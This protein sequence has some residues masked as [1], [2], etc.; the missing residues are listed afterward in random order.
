MPSFDEIRRIRLKNDYLEMKL[1]DE[2]PLVDVSV[3]GGEEPYADEYLL[4]IN[5]R[6]Y[7]GQNEMMD[8]CQVRI[9]LSEDYPRNAPFAFM[10]GQPK[11]YNPVWFKNGKWCSGDFWNASES[12][13]HFVIRL[14]QSLQFDPAV[15][16][17][18]R[19]ANQE[20]YKWYK[21][22]PRLFPCDVQ[23]LPELKT[24]GIM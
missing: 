19:P 5:V 8:S 7:C 11:A 23:P 10:E 3:T 12:L 6:T 1:I 22:N 15:V 18:A 4:T 14:L 17:P 2:S 20:A 24:P 16:N 9:T 13:G 21:K